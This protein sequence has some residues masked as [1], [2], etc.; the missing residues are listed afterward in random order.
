VNA[1]GY[2]DVLVA[3][4]AYDQGQLDEGVVWVFHGSAG[5]LTPNPSRVVEVNQD[6]ASLGSYVSTAGDVNGDGYADVVIGATHFDGGQTDEGRAFVY[7]GGAGG[8][9]AQPA[10]TTE[11][12]QAMA[13]LGYTVATAGDVNGDGYS[14]VIVGAPFFDNG[15][16]SEGAAWLYLG[17]PAGLGAPVWM[18]EGNQPGAVHGKSVSTVGDVN[19]DGYSDVAVGAPGFTF[20]QNGEGRVWVYYGGTEP[21]LEGLVGQEFAAGAMNLE[22]IPKQMRTDGA[23]PIQVLGVSDSPTG[24][25]LQA[26]GRVP[27]GRG[28]VR[29]QWEVKPAG[30]PF[31]GLG[32]GTG[33]AFDTGAPGAGGSAVLLSQ[34]VSGLI[35]ETL[36]HWRLR[37]LTDSPFCP[38]SP[39]FW[40]PDNGASEP[41]VRTAPGAAAVEAGASPVAARGH[42]E[43]SAPN[44][45]GAR[46]RIRYTLAEA[47]RARLAVYDAQGRCVAALRDQALPSGR[48]EADWD[49]RTGQGRALPSGVYFLRLELPGGAVDAEKLVVRR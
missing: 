14:E 47:G 27:G 21:G 28:Q 31:D 25:R 17:S 37:V 15:A 16:T 11:S 45:F 46:T 4:P 22:R 1:D 12:D 49:G 24:F 20:T 44:P 19:G 41:D 43:S 23:A 34:L 33:P 6:G 42:L 2:S 29:L 48:Y 30:I 10:W 39:W 3:V 8:L 35:P 7:H 26:L 5:G 36:Y 38:N 18:T 40:L 9:A 13:Y 32:L